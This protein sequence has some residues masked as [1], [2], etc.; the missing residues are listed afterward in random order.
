VRGV[1]AVRVAGVL[2]GARVRGVRLLAVQRRVVVM[3]MVVVTMWD[4]VLI[5]VI[6]RVRA[7]LALHAALQKLS[8]RNS[9]LLLK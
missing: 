6:I 9:R 2:V 7:L 1:D 3:V 8:K 4:A 5:V